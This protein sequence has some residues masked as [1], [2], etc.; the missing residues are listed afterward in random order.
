MKSRDQPPNL[1]PNRR[2]FRRRRVRQDGEPTAMDLIEEG[3]H[4]LRRTPLI[5]WAVYL[6]GVAPFIFGFLFFWTEMVSSGLAGQSLL[7]GALGLG[8]LFIWFKAAQA[9]FCDGLRETLY[10]AGD[11]P[12]SVG[13]WLIVI[14]RQA[15]WQ[16]TALIVLPIAFVITVPF[17]WA[18][19]FYQN[20][21]VSDPRDD[22]SDGDVVRESWRLARLWPEQNWMLLAL[23]G[24]VYLLS[25]INCLTLL[26]TGPFLLKTLLGIETVFS[27]SGI[28]LLNTTSLF[29]C[30]L[31]A[32]VVTDPLVKAVYLLRRH[33]CE[34]RRSGA[35]LL[36]RLRR[37]ELSKAVLMLLTL[38]VVWPLLDSSSASLGA[39]PSVTQSSLERVD[40]RQLDASIDEVLERREFTWRFPREEMNEDVEMEIGW[41]NSFKEMLERWKE[42]IEHWIEQLFDSEG[43]KDESDWDWDGFVGLGEVLSYV[44]IGCFILI[45]VYFAVRA[46]RLYQPLEALEGSADSSAE[47]VP[48]LNSEDVAADS[49]PRNRW[50]EMARELIAKG[51]YRLALRAYF[52]AQ[53]SA[54]ASEGI[55]VIRLAKSNREY[56]DEISRRAHGQVDLLELYRQEVSLFESVWYG[57][58][59]T[60]QAEIEEMERYLTES[61]VLV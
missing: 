60:G 29:V 39:E 32:Y 45:V 47:V 57:E 43:D 21:L 20:V 5:A 4:L 14:R 10:G 26:M 48:D 3:V 13:Q 15:F 24:V 52:L 28:H 35:D 44:L 34:S 2:R 19:A 9:F 50:V 27:R 51:E 8:A 54:L 7:P 41:L 33:Y 37:S 22:A 23:L 12:W 11:V 55:V 25:F 1:K 58:R 40:P 53:L 38:L 59:A 61:G 16:S 6:C 18:F 46:W 17:G 36:L 42:R 56:S 30:C 31:L 49:L